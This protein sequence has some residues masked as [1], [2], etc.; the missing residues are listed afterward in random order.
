M[1]EM[2]KNG[3]VKLGWFR[4]GGTTV[5]MNGIGI[6]K[7]APGQ[8]VAKLWA[9]WWTSIEGQR[10]MAEQVQIYAALPGSPPPPGWPRLEDLNPQRRTAEQ[11]VRANDYGAIFDDVFFK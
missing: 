2:E 4:D 10:V 6:I 3:P 7:D 8:D 11:T 1:F 5:G 9:S